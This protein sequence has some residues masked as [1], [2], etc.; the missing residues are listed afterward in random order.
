VYIDYGYKQY[1]YMGKTN[2]GQR[3]L[4]RRGINGIEEKMKG[5]KRKRQR[6]KTTAFSDNFIIKESRAKG[7]NDNFVW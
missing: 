1:T 6:D 4:W 7:E 3:L 2:S 5:R